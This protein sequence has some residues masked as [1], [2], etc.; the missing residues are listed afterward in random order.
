MLEPRY[1]SDVVYTCVSEYRRPDECLHTCLR[2]IFR[3]LLIVVLVY[4]VCTC[5]EQVHCTLYVCT[6]AEQVCCTLYVCTV[7]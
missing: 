7:C 6:C 1:M 3:H 5:A 2:T 4:R